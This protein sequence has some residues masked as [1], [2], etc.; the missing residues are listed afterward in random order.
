MLFRSLEI[1]VV[2]SIGLRHL[3]MFHKYII[4]R[5]RYNF[6]MKT[7]R[8]CGLEKD[9][10]EFYKHPASKDGVAHRCKLCSKEQGRVSRLAWVKTAVGRKQE[11]S[12]S[13]LKK[14][15]YLVHRQE[16]CRR[17]GFKPENSCRLT[18]DHIDRN[19]KNNDISNLQTLCHNC[20][21]YKSWVEM[22]EPEQL[23]ILNLIP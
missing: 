9:I 4:R 20:H 14:R 5:M 23:K 7:C 6:N 2:A 15:P 17:C 10:N 18:V 19:R 22:V 13:Q 21:N 8:V 16:E 12:K 1:N 11:R 3:I